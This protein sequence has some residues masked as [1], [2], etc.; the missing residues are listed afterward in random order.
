MVSVLGVHISAIDMGEAVDTITTWVTDRTPGRYV[1]V[2]GVHGVMECQRSGELEGVHNRADM[3]TPDGMPMVWACRWAGLPT[4]SRVYGP[5]LVRA[6]AGVGAGH[7][8][9][10][11][12][13]GGA[14]GVADQFGRRLC[15]DHPGLEL[16]GSYSPPFADEAVR[17]D[18][19]LIDEINASG[20]SL[21]FVGLST[22]KQEQWMALHRPLL[23]VPVLIGVGAAFDMLTGRLRQAPPVLQ[24]LGLEWLFRLAMEPRRLFWR[25][26][27]NNPGFIARLAVAPPRRVRPTVTATTS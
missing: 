9:S 6:L 27:R 26:V 22:P 13:V 1:T 17:L 4:T 3:T 12:C 14:P 21:L 16:A 8:W 2:T 25:Y 5:D 23:D 24:R 18:D 20:A 19:A 11:Y 7:G 15:A 10:V